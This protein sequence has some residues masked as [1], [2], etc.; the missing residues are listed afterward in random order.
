MWGAVGPWLLIWHPQR[1]KKK[2]DKNAL[3]WVHAR[4]RIIDQMVNFLTICLPN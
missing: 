2:K 3:K 4:I 1:K